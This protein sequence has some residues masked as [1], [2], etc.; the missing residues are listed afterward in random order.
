MKEEKTINKKPWEQQPHESKKIYARFL[1]YLNGKRNLHELSTEEGVKYSTITDNST[2][3][4]WKKRANAYDHHMQQELQEKT[5]NLYENLN[6]QGLNHMVEYLEDLNQ[7]HHDVMDR[8]NRKEISSG[9]AIKYMHEYIQCYREATE[10]YHIQCRRPLLPA[11]DVIDVDSVPVY[12]TPEEGKKRL[13]TVL[14]QGSNKIQRKELNE[15]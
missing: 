1:K 13:D 4:K 7:L 9:T 3:W 2:K 12:A 6:R 15:R 8:F 14:E 5:N 10:L 11:G